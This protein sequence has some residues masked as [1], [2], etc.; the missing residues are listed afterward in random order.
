MNEI[1]VTNITRK[2]CER[3]QI[4]ILAH[5]KELFPTERPG[6]PEN[7][8]ITVIWEDSPYSCTYRIG[9]KDGKA[10]SGVLRLKN[11]LAEALGD[12]L[13]QKLILKRTGKNKYYLTSTRL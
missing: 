10:R 12:R 7:Y 2:D 9:S 1:T 6:F 4:R 11:E 13:G 5:Q 8:D 3:K